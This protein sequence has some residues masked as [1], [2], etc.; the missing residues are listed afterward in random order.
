MTP[1]QFAA[2]AP[3]HPKSLEDYRIWEGLLRKWNARINLVAPKSLP[4]FWQRHALDS[5]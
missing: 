5:A 4:D 3:I 2:Q 1:E